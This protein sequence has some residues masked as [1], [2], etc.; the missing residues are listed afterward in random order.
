[1]PPVE[2]RSECSARSDGCCRTLAQ[3]ADVSDIAWR[4]SR[5]VALPEGASAHEQTP[6]RDPTS[7]SV[8]RSKWDNGADGRGS[9]GYSR[10]SHEI[11]LSGPRRRER[12]PGES[13]H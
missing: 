13:G 7:F 2:R 9:H 3:V 11:R 8:V 12:V 6:V 5:L 1:M 10:E 4:L